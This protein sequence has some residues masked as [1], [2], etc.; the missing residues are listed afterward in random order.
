[1]RSYAEA[2]RR[3]N[4]GNAEY[5]INAEIMEM[6]RLGFHGN[7]YKLRGFKVALEVLTEEIER[8]ENACAMA[9]KEDARG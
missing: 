7:N 1:M 6:K 3:R 4:L 2:K 5:W 9:G 8:I